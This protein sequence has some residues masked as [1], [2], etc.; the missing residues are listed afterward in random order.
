MTPLLTVNGL[1]KRYG[2]VV[3]ADGIDLEVGPGEIHA[4]IGPNGA[5]KTTLVGQLAG[6]I[7]PDRGRIS[8]CGRDLAAL[9]AWA[10]AGLGIAR[11]F[12]I[13]SLFEQFT[14]LDNT[15]LAVQAVRGHS[16]RFWRPA[17]G[18]QEQREAAREVLTRVGLGD[19]AGLL[20]GALSHGQKRQLELAMALAS[21]PRLLLLDEPLA[22]QGVA[23][24]PATIELLD[25]LR[26]DHAMLLVEHDMDAVFALADRITVLVG[27]RVVASGPPAAIRADPDVRAAYLGDA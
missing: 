13:T 27:G 7:R 22:G 17:R 14:V 19:T 15:A 8:F 4:V 5:G 18:V 2:A 12:Q 9:P 6:E 21:R 23:E 1:C 25:A 11:S 10:R 20:V 24:A 26:A 16:F 3:A